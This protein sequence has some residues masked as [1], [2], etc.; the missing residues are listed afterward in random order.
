LCHP[1]RS[2]RVTLSQKQLQR[3]KVVEN[4]VEGR[5]TV[6]EAA[7]MLQLSERQVKRLKRS[8]RAE[9]AEWVYHGN[10]DRAPA[11][12][13]GESVR[14]SV[15][16][17]AT[18]K[19]A[20]FNDTHL[21][22]KL[23]SH[24]GISISRQSV[25]RILRQAGIPSPQKR[26]APKYRSRRE[27]RSQEGAMLLVDASRH[28]WLE[29]RGPHLTLF[30]LVDD[31][32]S[33]VAA[34]H[35][36]LEAED[37]AGY[38]RL[39]RQQVTTHGIPL[40]VYR[41]QHGTMQRNDKHWSLEEELAGRQFPTQAGRMLEELGIAAIAA[42]TPQAK[43]RIERA[44][45]TFQDRL[46]SE[47]RLAGADTVEQANAV[48]TIFVADYNSR[49]ACSPAGAAKA[50]RKLDKRS[51]LNYIFSLRYRREVNNAHVI[52]A[53]PGVQ[54]QLPSLAGG[55]GYAG[56]HV[57]VCHQP[58]G[59]FHVYLDRALLHIERAQ[60]DAG[61]VRAHPFRKKAAP[62]KKKP[63]AV[64]PSTAKVFQRGLSKV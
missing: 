4:A 44:W 12:A 58:N 57:E 29:G 3:I 36:Q 21:Q 62:R 13:I 46:C 1:D 31:A 27:R 23:V 22:Q 53:I 28:D 34:A 63:L 56:R 30:G 25:R 50:W 49:F 35:F 60:P 7:E 39:F 10:R 55:R 54:I 2:W 17:F 5:L 47:L 6:A 51:D 19:Y 41:D 40:S 26:R 15:I 64:A 8:C 20:G 48:L 61:P 59:D 38:L 18:G 37:S 9:D 11:N 43:G 14:Q 32:T 33:Q 24:E 16:D 45:R 42:K 52:R